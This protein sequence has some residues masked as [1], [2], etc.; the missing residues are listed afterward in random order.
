MAVSYLLDI[1]NERKSKSNFIKG[2]IHIIHANKNDIRSLASAVCCTL[3]HISFIVQLSIHISRSQCIA[4][5]LSFDG[6]L[7]NPNTTYVIHICFDKNICNRF[8]CLCCCTGNASG[9]HHKLLISYEERVDLSLSLLYRI[10][11]LA[12]PIL[13]QR[14]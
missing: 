3:L 5:G 14:H 13:F 4:G 10:N 2:K 7:I 9:K 11:S 8:S 6:I 12:Y 1:Q